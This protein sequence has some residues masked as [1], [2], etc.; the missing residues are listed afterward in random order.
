MK[1]KLAA[2]AAIV[3]FGFSVSANAVIMSFEFSG[4][5]NHAS[6]I[7]Q[8]G[9][10]TSDPSYIGQSMF[11][12]ITLDSEALERFA[13]TL[14]EA[15]YLYFSGTAP[16]AVQSSLLIGGVAR[17]IGVHA[18][19]G[20]GVVY[21]DSRRDPTCQF[22]GG[23]V[24]QFSIGHSSQDDGMEPGDYGFRSLYLN[25]AALSDPLDPSAGLDYIDFSQYLD[26][27]SA[28]SLPL[29]SLFAGYSE[30]I[31]TCDAALVCSTSSELSLGFTVTSLARTI[32]SVSVPEPGALALFG[33]GLTGV[34][35][36]RRRQRTQA[37][38]VFSAGR[39]PG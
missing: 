27:F 3:A 31:M 15:S 29:A 13:H 35:A 24:D 17:D 12:T 33:L 32:Q 18:F 11:A 19:N 6:R 10:G 7:D 28:L 14:P 4:Y 1:N 30:G 36:S 39:A 2:S 25:S 16:E 21:T 20:G 38:R 23:P 22:C 5:V 34:F 9:V 8:N 26:A 37:N